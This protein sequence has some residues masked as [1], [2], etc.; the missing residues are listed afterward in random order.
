MVHLIYLTLGKLDPMALYN[1]EIELA[2]KAGG[3][4]LSRYKNA[5]VLVNTKADGEIFDLEGGSRG[6]AR[7]MSLS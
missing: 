7:L 1:N 4:I 6:L 2:I 3:E 5:S